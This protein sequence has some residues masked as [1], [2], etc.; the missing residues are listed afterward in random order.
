MS[1]NHTPLQRSHNMSRI[2]SSNTAPE[3]IVRS[4][5]HRMGYRYALHCGNLPGKP[6]IVLTKRKRIVFVHGCFWHA[7]NCRRGAVRPKTNNQYWT[8]KI[9]SNVRRDKKHLKALKAAGWLVMIVWNAKLGLLT[10][11]CLS[12]DSSFNRTLS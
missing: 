1:D 3:M 5:L 2:R 8:E 10:S 12:L 4:I 9:G 7:H 11:Y 6:D